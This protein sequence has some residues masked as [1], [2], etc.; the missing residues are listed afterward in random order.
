MSFNA[1]A[2]CIVPMM[3]VNGA[4]TPILQANGAFRWSANANG[5]AS[6]FEGTYNLNGGSLQ[7]SRASDNQQLSGSFTRTN[8]GGFNF[9]LQGKDDADLNFARN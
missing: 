5:K 1:S 8:S 7:L 9:K 6:S 2:A 3:P 4:K